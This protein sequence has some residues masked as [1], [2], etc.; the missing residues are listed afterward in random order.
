MHAAVWYVGKL[1]TERTLKQPNSPTQKSLHTTAAWI[2]FDR[3]TL[4]T[5]TKNRFS[6]SSFI[7]P[8]MDP[9]AQHRVLRLFHVNWLP[10]TCTTRND[11]PPDETR[12]DE[13][14]RNDLRGN[15]T[16]DF[17]TQKRSKTRGDSRTAD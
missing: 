5:V 1:S 4:M 6:S 3:L 9:M 11:T 2:D 8:E 10:E 13:N 17:Y 16:T 15:D 14:N 7:A 12:R